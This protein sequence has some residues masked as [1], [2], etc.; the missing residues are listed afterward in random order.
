MLHCTGAKARTKA[1]IKPFDVA[2]PLEGFL[3]GTGEVL[4]RFCRQYSGRP[5]IFRSFKKPRLVGSIGEWAASLEVASP[6]QVAEMFYHLMGRCGFG[7]KE[8][9]QAVRATPYGFR[10]LLP[11]ITRAAGWDLERRMELGR[12]SVGVLRSLLA[13][14]AAETGVRQAKKAAVGNLSAACANL[15]SRGKAAF[16]RELVLRREACG[17]VRDFLGGRDWRNVMPPK[18]VEPPRFA[19]LFG[20]EEGG[21]G[22]GIA[23]IDLEEEV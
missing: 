6:D 1:D 10:H 22:D 3:P 21:E 14:I 7:S 20:R 18:T 19:F 4:Q 2:V 15:Y 13:A 9:C 8:E 16:G 17:I 12:W 23:D 5:F 11:D